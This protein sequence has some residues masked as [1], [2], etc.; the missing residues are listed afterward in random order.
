MTMLQRRRETPVMQCDRLASRLPHWPAWRP[1]QD[2]TE[3]CRVCRRGR[4]AHAVDLWWRKKA[5]LRKKGRQEKKSGSREEAWGWCVECATVCMERICQE[6]L[7]GHEVVTC[8]AW[9][10][11]AFEHLWHDAEPPDPEAFDLHPGYERS[12]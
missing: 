1:V 12:V 11:A 8:D 7:L 9:S 2:C 4:P 6:C 10:D 5:L 3:P